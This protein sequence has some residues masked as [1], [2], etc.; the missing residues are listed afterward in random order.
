[1]HGRPLSPA[2]LKAYL[3]D[4]HNIRRAERTLQLYRREG[5]GPPYVRTGND[6]RY[7]TD[8]V[9]AWVAELFGDEVTSTA[10][11][12]ARRLTT[13]TSEEAEHARTTPTSVS[14][15][16]PAE[17]AARPRAGRINT[18]PDTAGARGLR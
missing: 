2:E 1:M 17:A 6:I 16:R 18:A 12:S 7:F 15:R 11:E 10:E 4:R 14:T 5:G 9:D 3:Q 13:A 8:S